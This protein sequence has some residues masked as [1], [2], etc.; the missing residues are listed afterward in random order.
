MVELTLA[1]ASYLFKY[2][3]HRVF[4]D[5]FAPDSVPVSLGTYYD[6]LPTR[7]FIVEDVRVTFK[8]PPHDGTNCPF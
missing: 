3:S 1:C 4:S 6:D 8:Y 7:E 2:L 5:V